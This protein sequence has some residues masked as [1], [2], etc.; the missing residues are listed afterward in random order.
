MFSALSRRFWLMDH[1]PMSN[2]LMNW[3]LTFSLKISI[4]H[5]LRQPFTAN[6]CS[7][8]KRL[9][10]KAGVSPPTERITLLHLEIKS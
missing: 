10:W 2:N 7:N 6:V 4:H 8:M 3:I 5:M 1:C 9:R